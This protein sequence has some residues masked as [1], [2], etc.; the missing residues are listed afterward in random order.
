MH[1]YATFRQGSNKFFEEGV[2][3]Y[4]TSRLIVYRNNRLI[5]NN[6]VSAATAGCQL[7]QQGVSCN[8]RMSAATTGCQLQQQGVSCNNRVSAATRGI[9]KYTM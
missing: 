4:L 9:C 5:C 1:A 7:Q 3:A 6:R 2:V 8:N